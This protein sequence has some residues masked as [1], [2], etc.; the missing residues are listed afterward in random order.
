MPDLFSPRL[1]TVVLDPVRA[2]LA[3]DVSAC[4]LEPGD[5]VHGRLV[6]PHCRYASTIEIAYPISRG[7]GGGYRVVIPEPS[8]WTPETPF[9]YAGKVEWRRGPDKI[10]AASLLH[11]LLDLRQ[12]PAGWR[13]NGKPFEPR[14]AAV[15]AVSEDELL[16]LRQAGFNVL[17]PRR[18]DVDLLERA[19]RIGFFLAADSERAQ[20]LALAPDQ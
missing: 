2:E 18:T 5:E 14:R 6:G 13:L 10:G 4:S 8:L 11:G 12:T 16:E 17:T 19:A 3:L 7:P 20:F 15:D 9:V 1:Q